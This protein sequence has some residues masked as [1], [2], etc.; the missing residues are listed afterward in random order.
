M[1]VKVY[2][3]HVCTPFLITDLKNFLGYTPPSSGRLDV[4]LGASCLL[5]DE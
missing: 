5:L 1:K 4:D 3:M 2:A